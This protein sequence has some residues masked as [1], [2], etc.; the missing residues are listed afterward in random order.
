M[1]NHTIR[2]EEE[3]INDAINLVLEKNRS[4]HSVS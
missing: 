2:Y 4:V 1:S 3:F